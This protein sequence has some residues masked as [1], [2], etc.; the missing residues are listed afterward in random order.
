M[1]NRLR[2]FAP[3]PRGLESCL[4][5]ELTAAGAAEIRV[6]PGGV[7]FTGDWPVL[8]RVHLTSRI[9]TRVLV[10]VGGGALPH[11][12]RRG[13]EGAALYR[14]AR[15]VAWPKWVSPD[16]RLRVDL[17][18][19]RAACTDSIPFLTLRVKDAI[20]DA[21]RAQCGRRPS[22]DKHDPT[23]RA[24]VFL[25]ERGATFYWDTS[26]APLVQR[27]FKSATTLAPLK[28]NLAAGILQVI[29][30]TPT[31]PLID[32][33]CG[34]GTFLLEAAMRAYAIPPGLFRVFA[35]EQWH[36][37][38]RQTWQQLRNTLRAETARHIA[39]LRTKHRE[40]LLFAA[41]ADPRQIAAAQH[42][43]QKLEAAVEASLPIVWQ[44]A[45]AEALEPPS[46]VPPGYWV[47]NPPY[48]VRLAETEALAAWYP[49]LGDAL[50]RRWAG[51]TAHFL[52]A[53][54]QFAKRIGLRPA[55]KWHLD[56]G[57]L[58]CVLLR[59]PIV[60]GSLKRNRVMSA[61]AEA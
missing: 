24:V 37:L 4:G 30:W 20:C 43:W 57:P 26:G 56:N 40:P 25:D 36:G 29:G 3:C 52:T 15:T 58:R 54:S 1:S 22:V 31:L 27:G 14:L 7:A 55:A 21:L 50:K 48:G 34:S 2:A 35:F 10:A 11:G 12:K 59:Y 53:D 28:E 13:E 39:V 19:T 42:N 6:R 9:A 33:M 17:T 46:E 60:A 49:V 32:P 38:D 8:M 44:T 61:E 16:A 41:D 23:F 45:A 51:W 18:V 47:T 5:D